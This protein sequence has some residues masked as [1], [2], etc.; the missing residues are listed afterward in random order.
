MLGY[1]IKVGDYMKFIKKYRILIVSVLLVILI[2]VGVILFLNSKK[3]DTGRG[4]EYNFGDEVIELPGTTNYKNDKLSSK[5]CLNHIC[6]TDAVFYYNDKVGRV[7]Y[8]ITNTSKKNKSGYLKMIFNN[9]SL[10]VVYKD[11]S[12]NETIKSE[13][14]YMGIEIEDKS[15]YKLEKLTDEEISKIIK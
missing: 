5:H 8:K 2:V 13:S 12:P 3:K 1:L 11:L 4:N 7:E 15:D 9:Q 10:L 6:I 14:Q